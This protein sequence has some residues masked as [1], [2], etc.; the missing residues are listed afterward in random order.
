MYIAECCALLYM[1]SCLVHVEWVAF[2]S[3][4]LFIRVSGYY[5]GMGNARGQAQDW[6][7]LT[8]MALQLCQMT[9]C[10]YRWKPQEKGPSPLVWGDI[11]ACLVGLPYSVLFC[12]A[13]RNGVI[14]ELGGTVGVYLFVPVAS[15][16]INKRLHHY[17]HLHTPLFLWCTWPSCTEP[18]LQ[19]SVTMCPGGLTAAKTKPTT[20]RWVGLKCLHPIVKKRC[21]THVHV[22]L[23]CLIVSLVAHY[24]CLLVGKSWVRT[25]CCVLN[26][27][28]PSFSIC[29]SL[30][31]RWHS[32]RKLFGCL[33]G[34]FWTS[35]SP[36]MDQNFRSKYGTT[37]Q[38][39]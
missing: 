28:L 27:S 30:P 25:Y 35:W 18:G 1:W 9:A 36:F 32:G 19:C 12:P 6:R 34:L 13:C 2:H 14:A 33:R 16:C 17:N 20:H 38:S 26:A 5:E 10:T 21:C 8:N 15:D 22:G 11:L 29:L 37:L 23:H 3:H 24:A 31:S 39:G 4:V 7:S